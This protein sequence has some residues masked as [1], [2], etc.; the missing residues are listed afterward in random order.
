[1]QIP[2]TL[3]ICPGFRASVDLFKAGRDLMLVVVARRSRSL[4]IFGRS[5]IRMMCDTAYPA[6]DLAPTNPGFSK[7]GQITG[8]DAL[9]D[10]HP[11]PG[12]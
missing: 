4:N 1:V 6:V 5:F 8:S 11:A 7:H 2:P 12:R 3:T 10:H 9:N